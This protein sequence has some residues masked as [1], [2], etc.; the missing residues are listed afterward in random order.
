MRADEQGFEDDLR[1]V[2]RAGGEPPPLSADFEPR[3]I[4][5]L[6]ARRQ[7]DGLPIPLE[8][9]AGAAAVAVVATILV[10]AVVGRLGAGPAGIG[11]RSAAPAVI[12]TGAESPDASAPALV[13]GH[14]WDL[15]FD[16]PATWSLSG[17]AE[18]PTVFPA[19]SMMALGSVG[20]S[21]VIETCDYPSPPPNHT[22]KLDQ[23]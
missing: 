3:V 17:S 7:P 13:R 2:L 15:A 21:T 20:T 14:I 10:A 4:A 18:A 1:R 19:R 11:G 8:W 22:G 12:G 5:L 23:E 6:P 9:A 16:Y